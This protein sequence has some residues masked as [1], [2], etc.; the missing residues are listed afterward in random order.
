VRA[1]SREL[2]PTCCTGPAGAP[3]PELVTKTIFVP[4]MTT[5]T[6]T[7]HD[8]EPRFEKR[9]REVTVTR[10]VPEKRTQCYEETVYDYKVLTKTVTETRCK[11]VVKQEPRTRTFYIP[12]IHLRPVT[13]TVFRPVTELI[14]K[15]FP[16]LVEETEWR[17]GLKTICDL[18]TEKVIRK[19][20]RD[21]GHWETIKTRCPTGCGEHG[22]GETAC[23][24]RKVWVPRLVEHDVEMDCF[25]C[26]HRQVPYHYEITVIRPQ[27]R[28]ELV[29]VVHVEPLTVTRDEEYVVP[30]RVTRT[31]MVDVVHMVPETVT[32]EVTRTIA[33][34]RKEQRTREYTVFHCVPQRK[35][36]EYSVCVLVPV[37]RQ[38][39]VPVCKMVPQQVQV[40]ACPPLC[41]D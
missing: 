24:E 11:A 40:P 22:C 38:V 41:R 21:E 5:E 39:Q 30:V 12:E 29:P 14:P 18:V 28:T 32:R 31:E 19:V 17:E 13:E 9:T 26:E 35:I 23:V 15:T 4:C 36:E 7:I 10:Y 6:R 8:T 25:R 3:V 16:I 20:H 33:V 34:P 37:Q 1:D 27:M 2:S